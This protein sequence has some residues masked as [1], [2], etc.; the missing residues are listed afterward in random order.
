MAIRGLF[1]FQTALLNICRIDHSL[2]FYTF[3]L[4][5]FSQDGRMGE[6]SLEMHLSSPHGADNEANVTLQRGSKLL[7]LPV[8]VSKMVGD[9]PVWL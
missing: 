2:L 7:V 8:E 4:P 5:V 6:Q 3:F 1:I 9:I